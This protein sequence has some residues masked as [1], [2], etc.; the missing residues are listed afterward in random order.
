MC[1]PQ[2][3]GHNAVPP[4]KAR[5]RNPSISSPALYHRATALLKCL[6]QGHY[7]RMQPGEN[8]VEILL[9]KFNTGGFNGKQA[10]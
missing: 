6:A 7:R 5:T 2:A 8:D 3:Q 10:P 9:E 1:L 4:D